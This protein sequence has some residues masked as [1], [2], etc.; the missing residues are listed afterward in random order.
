MCHTI[1]ILTTHTHIFFLDFEFI[2]VKD[3]NLLKHL[4]LELIR[5]LKTPSAFQLPHQ[6]LA[7]VDS[8]L[9]LLGI[10]QT[11]RQLEDFSVSIDYDPNETY[12]LMKV[13]C[14]LSIEM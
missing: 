3:I 4:D 9:E 5:F 7:I 2:T 12:E 13:K 6:A 10:P 8:T 11:I 1:E 14:I